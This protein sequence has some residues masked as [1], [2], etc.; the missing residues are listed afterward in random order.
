MPTVLYSPASP[1]SAKVRMAAAHAGVPIA[2]EIV[3]TN[4][5]PADLVDANPLGKIPVLVTDEG[6][7]VYDSAVIVQW[8]NRQSK[9]ALFPRNP[10]KRAEAE[11]MESLA[12][13]LCDCLLANVYERR[14]RPEEL[15][16]QPW[17]DKQ[18]E[19]AGRVL[20]HLNA[21]PPKLPKRIT[22]GQIAVR[23]ALGY[24]Q[25]RFAGQWER[26]RPRLKRWAARFD[27]K[28]P[29]LVPYLPQG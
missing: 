1:Y 23:A 21:N 10:V 29:D 27:D 9:N 17:L 20:D 3:D 8:L 4:A 24:L 13:G 22:A 14:F 15:V 19:K 12:D 18:W 28:F 2:S 16:Y 6:A 7:S 5:A 11:T 25:L 26:G